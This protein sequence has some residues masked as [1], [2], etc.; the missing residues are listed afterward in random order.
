MTD[1]R[2][3][4]PYVRAPALP[5]TARSTARDRVSS[6]PGSKSGPA[7]ARLVRAATCRRATGRGPTRRAFRQGRRP[8]GT[9]SFLPSSALAR[10]LARCLNARAIPRGAGPRLPA[11]R[12]GTSH[13]RLGSGR[14]AA[15][16]TLSVEIKR[17]VTTLGL[18]QVAGDGV[19]GSAM[20]RRAVWRFTR[21]RRRGD[22]RPGPGKTR[23][24]HPHGHGWSAGGT[25]RAG[26]PHLTTDRS[27][28]CRHGGRT[29]RR[30][31][32]RG[33]TGVK[34]LE[35]LASC[36]RSVSSRSRGTGRRSARAQ[37]SALLRSCGL[38]VGD[39][40][41]GPRARG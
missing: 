38:K 25:R 16:C 21:Q 19:G 32:A 26:A 1:P 35:Q 15:A 40:R 36:F 8:P 14:P 29:R 13:G 12:P 41:R 7:G 27:R 17:L 5:C 10:R 20:S 30:V 6:Y 22:R 31:H 37:D 24:V 3:R 2:A 39:P 9:G 23:A 18:E 33:V 11:S 4:Q 34:S 28:A